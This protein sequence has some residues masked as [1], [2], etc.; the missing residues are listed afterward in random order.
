MSFFNFLSKSNETDVSLGTLF[1]FATKK[2]DFVNEDILTTYT[3]ILTDVISRT[4]GIGEKHEASLW[5][6]CVQSE[7][8]KGLVTLLAEAMTYKRD[9]Y[10]VYVSSVDLLRVAT[11]DEERRIAID[12]KEKSESKIGVF[13]S[14]KNYRRTT[15]LKIYSEF[16]YCI[17]ASLNKLLG[18]SQSLQVK[19]K[20]LRSGVS[21]SDSS[22]AI[23][24]AKAIAKAIGDGHD[25]LIDA[26]DQ[27]VS[28]SPDTS[29]SE[30][31]ITFLNGKKAYILDL[32]LSYISGEQT[33]GIGSTGEADMRAVERGLKQY[34]H[35][36]IKPVMK[37]IFNI[38]VEFRSQDFREINSALEVIKTFEL[39]EGSEL[40]SKETMIS[41]IC[42]V[43]HIDNKAEN[44][45]LEREKKERD[46]FYRNNAPA[47]LPPIDSGISEDE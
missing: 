30:K 42:R 14:F 46:D 33:G 24:Q 3:K 28:S 17:L 34:F 9:L 27:I 35:S 12:Y 5:D 13:I 1:P 37:V 38:N 32:P 7:S 8:S 20:N 36:I 45:R 15:M 39:V 10:L 25:V 29:S 23:G 6:N 31:S 18:I 44:K 4:H 26:D 40:L 43:F 11:P 16:E 2:A 19:I 41:L 22:I 47:T 21:L